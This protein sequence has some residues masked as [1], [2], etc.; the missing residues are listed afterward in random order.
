MDILINSRYISDESQKHQYLTLFIQ[1]LCDGTDF[2]LL[3]KV[4]YYIINVMKESD[5]KDELGNEI[6]DRYN[7]FKTSLNNNIKKISNYELD[8]WD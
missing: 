7:Y 1:Y 2:E 5:Y 4:S 6:I 3:V 8:L